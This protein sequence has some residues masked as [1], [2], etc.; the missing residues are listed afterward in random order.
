KG[1]IESDIAN[2]IIKLNIG[3]TVLIPASL[4]NYF[5]KTDDIIKILRVTL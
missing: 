3:K 1:S 2:N 5:I 4:G